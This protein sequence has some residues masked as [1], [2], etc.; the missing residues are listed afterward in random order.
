MVVLTGLLYVAFGLSGHHLRNNL[1]PRAGDLSWRAIAVVLGG[2]FRFR[3]PPESEA[4]SYNVLQRLSY[5]GVVFILFPLL[6]WSGLAMSP[7]FVSAVPVAVTSLG[8]QQSA[9][10]V[11]LFTTVLLLIFVLIH[12]GMVILAGFRHRVRAMITGRAVVQGEHA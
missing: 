11:H 5:L 1:L 2:H 12:I 7:A 6:I 10:T 3:R 8:G 4:W 9:R